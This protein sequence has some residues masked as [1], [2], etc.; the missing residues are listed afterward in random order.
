MPLLCLTT[1]RG[2]VWGGGGIFQATPTNN[3]PPKPLFYPQNGHQWQ[4]PLIKKKKKSQKPA[5]SPNQPQIFLLPRPPSASNFTPSG[6]FFFTAGHLGPFCVIGYFRPGK[7][8][9]GSLWG[10]L[11]LFFG[12]IFFFLRGGQIWELAGG[13]CTLGT[14]SS[15]VSPPPLQAPWGCQRGTEPPKNWGGS[16]GGEGAGRLGPISVAKARGGGVGGSGGEPV[17]FAGAGGGV[18]P[19]TK[20]SASG[21]NFFSGLGQ[22]L[23]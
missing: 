19:L 9:F 17:A 11:L 8:R 12:R 15:K 1:C 13:G 4:I 18:S 3:P 14:A 7:G 10:N 22:V 16:G 23:G 21:I 20:P 5:T 6:L 2:S